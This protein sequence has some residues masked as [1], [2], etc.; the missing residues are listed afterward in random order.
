VPREGEEQPTR[1]AEDV[2]LFRYALVREAADE[3]LSKAERGRTVRRL[4]ETTH[5]GPDGSPVV[6][7]RPTIDHWVRAYRSRGFAARTAAAAD[8]APHAGGTARAR[9]PSVSPRWQ[10][11]VPTGSRPGNPS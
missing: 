2:A 10:V 7:S 5:S 9:L 8:R 3:K 1:R 6:V 4:A 11:L